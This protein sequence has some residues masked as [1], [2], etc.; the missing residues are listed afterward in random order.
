MASAGFQASIRREADGAP[1]G[2]LTAV[3]SRAW[4]QWSEAGVPYVHHSSDG[5]DAREDVAEWRFQWTAPEG[6]LARLVLHVAANSGNGDAS[7]LGDFV[8]TLEW[9]LDS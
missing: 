6:P 2:R 8:Y 3:D 9:P 1:A 5:A 4:I 7:P